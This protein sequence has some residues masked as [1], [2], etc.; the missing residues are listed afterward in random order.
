M[1][2]YNRGPSHLHCECLGCGAYVR[3]AV[4]VHTASAEQGT[5]AARAEER[6]KGDRWIL[7][8]CMLQ[9]FIALIP[10]TL[11]S[12]AAILVSLFVDSQCVHAAPHWHV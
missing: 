3:Y 8:M 4:E 10:T 2:I 11:A 7:T 9:A 12:V 1:A 6:A 5:G